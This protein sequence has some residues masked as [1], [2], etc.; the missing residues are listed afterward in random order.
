MPDHD[1]LAQPTTREIRLSLPAEPSSVVLA[2]ELARHTFTAWGYPPDTVQDSMLVMSEIVTNA[3][4][5]ARGHELRLRYTTKAGAPLLE[6][7][8]PSPA[9]PI[10]RRAT[11][12]DESGRG[13]TIINAYAKD[14]GTRP[15]RTGEGKTIW[16]LMPT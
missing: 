16:A 12:T 4:A 13:L 6:C 14:S 2:R 5:A 9:H 3:V 1:H 15:S 8:D 10:P 11:D 7:W